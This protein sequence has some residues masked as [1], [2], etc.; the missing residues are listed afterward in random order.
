MNRQEFIQTLVELLVT[1]D[2]GML[3]F[4]TPLPE[5]VEEGVKRAIIGFGHEVIPAL[6]TILS[7]IS[8]DIDPRSLVEVLGNIGDPS[9][10]PYIIDFHK[11]RSNFLSGLISMN[12]LRKLRAEEG[13]SYISELLELQAQ[14]DQTAFNTGA[15]SIVA[16]MSLGEWNDPRAIKPLMAAISI[17]GIQGLPEAAVNALAKYPQAHTFLKNLAIEV[18]S[19]KEV[20]DKATSN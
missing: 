17:Q 20:I 2:R 10:A 5:A 19:L 6:H 7:N 14:G 11:N 9:S 3:A 18:P 8:G 12:A 1:V 15:E 16:C 13:Y 4:D